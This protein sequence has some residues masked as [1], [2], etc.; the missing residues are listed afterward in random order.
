[1]RRVVAISLLII[2]LAGLMSACSNVYDRSFG[3]VYGTT[4]ELKLHGGSVRKAKADIIDML[5]MVEMTLSTAI[6]SS[7]VYEINNSE[8]NQAINVSELTML[9]FTMSK[10]YYDETE[11]AFNVAIFPIVRLWNLDPDN[12]SEFDLPA[13]EDIDSLLTYCSMNYFVADEEGMTITRLSDKA[14]LDF[15]AIA[16]G[17]ALQ[18]ALDISV[19]H[20]IKS[21]IINIGGAV[22]TVGKTIKVGIRNPRES[23]N[24]CFSSFNMPHGESVNT[25]GDYERYSV[26]DDVRYHHI[27]DSKTG[28]PVNNGIIG[29]TVVANDATVSDVLATAVFVMGAEAGMKYAIDKG[30]KCLIIMDDKTYYVSSD[31]DIEVIEEGYTQAVFDN[32]S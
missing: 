9:M 7:E 4:Y 2:I 23:S 11:G 22:A 19:E 14:M 32:E 24:V 18:K 29:V 16:K 31:F 5:E 1:M 15:G 21:G 3:F 25:S 27:I 30:V 17:Y 12:N 8:P 13:Q 10:Q 6:E 28:K 20:S 26:I